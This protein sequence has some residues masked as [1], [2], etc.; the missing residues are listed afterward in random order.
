MDTRKP[1][2]GIVGPSK[3][4]KSTLQ[5]GLTRLGYRCRHIA[6][7]HSF[8]PSMWNVV[9]KPDVLI[10]LDVSFENTLQR[11][12]PKW[13]ETDFQEEHS[14]LKQAK[15]HADLIVSTDDISAEEVLTRVL[16]FLES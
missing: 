5:K 12:Q 2:I 7:E 14:R 10:Y 16:A 4:G 6:Q 13:K 8:V 9:G 1:L 11:G 3:A 15:E